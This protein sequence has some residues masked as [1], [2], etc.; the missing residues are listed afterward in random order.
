MLK[1]LWEKRRILL[2]C[3]AIAFAVFLA[4]FFYV[5]SSPVDLS[6]QRARIEA[7]IENRTGI[8]VMT[9][10]VAL[11]AFPH[12]DL[13]I[14]GAAAFDGND[15]FLKI[16][17]M[18]LVLPL[19]S[20][21]SRSINISSL[22]IDGLELNVARNASG[23]INLSRFMK[24]SRPVMLKK[25]NLSDARASFKDAAANAAFD[26]TGIKAAITRTPKGFDYAAEA[27]L[28]PGMTI[29]LR[30]AGNDA[31]GRLEFSGTCSVKGFD[32]ALLTPYIRKSL[33]N[34]SVSGMAGFAGSYSYDGDM[35]AKGSLTYKNAAIALPGLLAK[36]L[37]SASG[38]VA[39]SFFRDKKGAVSAVDKATLAFDGFSLS[40]SL[41]VK[42]LAANNG[43][44]V[45]PIFEAELS[46][47][48]APVRTLTAYVPAPYNKILEKVRPVDGTAAL[49]SL[50]VSGTFDDLKDRS[51]YKKPGFAS[52]SVE[53]DNVKVNYRNLEK[54]LAGIRGV[55]AFKDNVLSLEHFTGRH[56]AIIVSDLSGEV[57]DPLRR[58]GVAV[59]ANY[60]LS[61]TADMETSE[62][63]P[64]AMALFKDRARED[65]EKLGK[66]RLAGKADL[67]LKLKGAAYSGALKFSGVDASYGDIPLAIKSLKGALLF[68][69]KSIT[70]ESVE[71]T[72]EF[73]SLYGVEGSV[74]NYLS[75]SPMLDIK[76]RGA[77]SQG[78]VDAAFRKW[79]IEGP[80]YK[81]S[82]PFT[83]SLRGSPGSLNAKAS[84]DFTPVAIEYKNIIKKGARVKAFAKGSFGLGSTELSIKDFTL[85]FGKAA[86]NAGGR[87]S[88][89]D[90]HA[91]SFFAFSKH[92]D[93]GD[94]SHVAAFLTDGTASGGVLAFDLK[95]EKN[96]Q[97]EKPSYEGEV[98]FKDG[99]FNAVFLA[100][101]VE[102]VNASLKFGKD[103]VHFALDKLSAGE[104]E[105]SARLDAQNRIINFEVDSPGFF[106]EDFIKKA[107][108]FQRAEGQPSDTAPG[109]PP[110]KKQ[111][112]IKDFLYDFI[113]QKE[114]AG[115]APAFV[116]KGIV[117]IKKGSIMGR[118]FE[119]LSA[120]FELEKDALYI[121][122]IT[123]FKNQ[124][125]AAA[126]VIV[127]RG[128]SAPLLFAA[129]MEFAGVQLEPFFKEM[130]AKKMILSGPVRG[131]MEL[132]G[133]R[134]ASPFTAGLNGSA[135]LHSEDG[136]LYKFTLLSKIFSI[137]NILSI[138]ELF[139]DG[140]PYKYISGAFTVKDGV[141]STNNLRLDASSMRM[142]ALGEINLPNTT[143]DAVLAMHPFVTIDKIIS[144]IPL[145]GWI[146]GGRQESTLSMYYDIVGPLKEP[147]VGPAPIKGLGVGVL[148]ILQ[149]LIEAPVEL[150]KPDSAPK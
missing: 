77:L 66:A 108:P 17:S 39:M 70:L 147:E 9:Q 65:I 149:R 115:A 26:V 4:A 110:V 97:D 42:T 128:A 40:G 150:L 89:G 122:P 48:P 44:K 37:T 126:E 116:G 140:L 58:L 36:P 64:L 69:N 92:V 148:G 137:V 32:L 143:I 135:Y 30:G 28:R 63:V 105:V 120:G 90:G 45:P 102:K 54:P 95:T 139:E 60:R 111:S 33:P 119:D 99:R 141:I 85:A 7:I 127:Y 103:A 106:L 62:L 112:R 114:A 94:L 73:G 84:L 15:A 47:T 79:N 101:P 14:K 96:A 25:L 16:R 71:G 49:K 20:I 98:T 41:K 107:E 1:S 18:R 31:K 34:A 8:K 145:A 21:F 72:D 56:G 51:A 50:S 29:S 82:V 68:D 52:A 121:R 43:K 118:T 5:F 113:E 53:L 46:S 134:G 10:S 129:K 88:L 27:A 138:T 130:G 67:T 117:K 76:T 91:Y 75:K 57:K 35:R 12:I 136:K 144:T 80:V 81:G 123:Y 13:T 142:S 104:T 124:G 6:S 61:L 132:A 59:K 146:I 125:R 19:L 78:T 86:V 131:T 23:D 55:L 83:V 2:I 24:E 3:A 22:D 38:S 74:K 87:L 109:A 93:V 100:K 11:K 133:R